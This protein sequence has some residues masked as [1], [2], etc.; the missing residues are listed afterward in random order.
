MPP[1]AFTLTVGG[2]QARMRVTS[3]TLAPRGP[4][5]VLVDGL[6][7]SVGWTVQGG[8][9]YEL[10]GVV[11]HSGQTLQWLRENVAQYGDADV[12]EG[13]ARVSVSGVWP[14]LRHRR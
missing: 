3:S 10:E 5:P 13:T 6:T 4:K 1:E 14:G 2:E 9:D 7:S 8:T 11:F 12:D